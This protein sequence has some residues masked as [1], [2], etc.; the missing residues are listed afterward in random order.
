ML[1][2]CKLRL[3]HLDIIDWNIVK[4]ISLFCQRIREDL[5]AL[6]CPRDQTFLPQMYTRSLLS[7]LQVHAPALFV[8]YSRDKIRDSDT[9]QIFPC[10]ASDGSKLKWNRVF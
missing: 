8:V 3:L 5:R 7:D 9:L 6:L 1:Q 4:R 2:P 10:S